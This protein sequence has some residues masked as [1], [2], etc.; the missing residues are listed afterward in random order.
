MLRALAEAAAAPCE[1]SSPR[2]RGGLAHKPFGKALL[3][4]TSSALST[5]ISHKSTLQEATGLRSLSKRAPW[6][7]ASLPLPPRIPQQ[8]RLGHPRGHELSGAEQQGAL[9]ASPLPPDLPPAQQP[10]GR[11]GLPCSQQLHSSLGLLN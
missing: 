4:H 1:R 7:G 3:S 11:T 6:H 9:P 5:M 10:G 8:P 2:Q